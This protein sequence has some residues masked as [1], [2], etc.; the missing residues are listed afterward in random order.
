MNRVLTRDNIEAVVF[1]AVITLGL[2]AVILVS[3]ALA[4]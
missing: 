2:P 1:A 3:Q 4:G